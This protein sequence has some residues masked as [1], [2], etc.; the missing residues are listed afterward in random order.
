MLIAQSTRK[1]LHSSF[2]H[3]CWVRQ[4]LTLAINIV[5]HKEEATMEFAEDVT[6]F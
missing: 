2:P 5:A 6:D 1:P 4:V 3:T